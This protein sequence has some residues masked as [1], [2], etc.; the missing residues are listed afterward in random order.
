M[1]GA[2]KEQ[3]SISAES[4]K[5]LIDLDNYL[6]EMMHISFG[7]RIKKQLY[8]Y[9]PI[10]IACGGTEEQAID[11]ILT[12]KVLR[13]LEAQNPSFIKAS[14]GGLRGKLIELFGAQAMPQSLDYFD[15]L[16]NTL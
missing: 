15:M 9:I 16:E 1:I 3:Y 7:N 14:L 6:I 12:R 8:E 4:E 5:K 2:A 11:D 10:M 13:K